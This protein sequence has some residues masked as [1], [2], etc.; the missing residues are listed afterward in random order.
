MSSKVGVCSAGEKALL[1]MNTMLE[2][3][4]HGLTNALLFLLRLIW[5][6]N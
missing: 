2:A 1:D 5:L 3:G 4:S 6:V